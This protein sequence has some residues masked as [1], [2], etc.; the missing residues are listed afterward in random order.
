MAHFKYLNRRQE[1][2]IEI[3]DG[4]RLQ[5]KG[6][7]KELVDDWDLELDAAESQS[8][9][10]GK[11]GRKPTK[12]V[13]N[14]VLSMPARTSP[15]RLLAASQ[16]FAREQ[17]AMKHRYA[18]VLHTDRPH[19]HVHLVVRA[20]SE[21]G[22]RLNVRK[23]TLR[24]WR[25]EFARH[26]REHGIEANATERAIH[27]VAEPRKLDG[28]YRPMRD[29]KRFSTHMQ[30]RI[31]SVAS[32]LLAGGIKVERGKSKLVATRKEV[33]RG[34]PT[35][36]DILVD[37]GH[38]ELASQVRRFVDQM[39]PARTEREWIAAQLLAHLPPPPMRE[40]APVR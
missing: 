36:G 21:D 30:R 16:S 39:A 24:E 40:R 38:P 35:V 10:S 8:S 17:F 22:V 34:W 4:E 18:M 33:E 26:L 15:T 27:G 23:A 20:M 31:E 32:D 29:R 14:I 9:Y 1:F 25:R 3:D 7:I 6:S 12:L 13:H 2:E 28:I 37:D 19:P 5:G 11:P